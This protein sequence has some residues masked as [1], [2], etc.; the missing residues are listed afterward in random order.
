MGHVL[1]VLRANAFHQI[2]F[3]GVTGG[4]TDPERLGVGARIDNR[5][6][7]HKSPQILPRVTFEGVQLVGMRMAF[8]ASNQNRSLRSTS[9]DYQRVAVPS[10]DGIAVPARPSVGFGRVLT[11]VDEDLT[12]A[13]NVGFKK[14]K[15]VR[16]LLNNPAADRGPCAALPQEGEGGLRDRLWT[17]DPSSAYRRRA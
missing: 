15:D 7:N 10:T 5:G 11:A 13:V 3:E 1:V 2:V 14:D 4:I 16:V 17:A 6:F 8:F 12:V 9:V